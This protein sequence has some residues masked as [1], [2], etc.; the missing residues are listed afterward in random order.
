[1]ART[2]TL[3]HALLAGLV[4]VSGLAAAA[5]TTAAGPAVSVAADPGSHAAGCRLGNGI[6]HV[7]SL[8]FD[9]VHFF[10]D[11]PAVPSDLELMPSLLNF[12]QG[13]GTVLSNNHTPLIAH[14]ADDSLTSYTGLY[15][16]RQGMGI[17]NSYEV[18][19]P[20][21]GVDPAGSF[22]YWTSPIYDK[23][24]APNP[25]PDALPGQICSPTVPATQTTVNGQ[26]AQDPAPW[27]PF[28]R[29]GCNVGDVSTANMVLENT[30]PDIVNLFGA[31]SP[32]AAQLAADKD[33]YKDQETND[34]VGVS[35][36]CAQGAAFCAG[37]TGTKFGQS[38]PSATAITDVLP[39]EPGG[40]SGFQALHGHRYVS[41]QLAA[42][43]VTGTDTAG[44]GVHKAGGSSY[45]VTDP[46]GNLVDLN[47]KELDGQYVPTPGFPGFGPI[48]AAQT[49]A[50]VADMQESGVPVTYAYISDLHEK[51]YGQ[52]GCTSPGTALG[53]GD[54]CY[55]ANAASYNTA[56]AAFFTRLA[57]DGITP[58]NTLFVVNA[59]EGDHFA[60]ANAGRAVQ[61]TCTTAPLGCTY[62]KGS[63][64]EL[65]V[66]IHG[67]LNLQQGDTTP[68]YSEPQGAAFYVTGGQPAATVRQLERDVSQ[69]TVNDP[70]TGNAA[71]PLTR[72]LA[73]A[74]TEQLLHFTNADPNRTPTFTLFPQPDAYLSSGTGDSC[75]AGTT[76]LT[77][78][79][80]CTYLNSSYAWNHGYYAP[81]IDTTWLG[82]AGPGVRRKGID[83]NGPANGPTL[84]VTVPAD[85]TTGTWADQTDIR[86][87]V[88][89]L[90]GLRDSYVHDGRV[91][92]EVLK[93]DSLP[94]PLT[95]DGYTPL[96]AC[97][98]QLDASVGRFGT[99]V[100]VATTAAVRTGSSTDD[101]AYTAF[102]AR[103]S[104]LG[105]QRDAVATTI[106]NRLDA[107]AFA[108]AP[109]HNVGGLVGQCRDVLGAADQL[110]QSS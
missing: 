9:N 95:E 13:N 80:G 109:L 82:L 5:V 103:L 68:F 69:T 59:D 34:Y 87:T 94:E 52:T 79:A 51:K 32:E 17:S 31:T 102:E 73:D 3:G 63:I 11:N 89:A 107:A 67:L 55:L 85:G 30:S 108:G 21:G 78:A 24:T 43:A 81:E 36:H 65:A 40:Y 92:A 23:V 84:N 97:Y 93:S 6:T 33:T 41:P 39:T 4:G 105:T 88:L 99:D 101:S 77:A 10:R 38:G 47:G 110:A 75:T 28:T 91:L 1:M 19:N 86:P 44:D 100:L 58:T 71:E 35:V 90:A 8:T 96:A 45:V 29:A 54:P 20:T 104:A 42:G 56:F 74:T 49:L 37:A 53:P 18:Y 60:G 98:K 62:P 61:P 7:V 66:N 106:K 50:Y 83:G 57:A 64:G 14:T 76:A 12:L 26:Q 27:V 22:A 25:G 16:D 15:G 72:Y 70:Y 46:A 2:S 48:S